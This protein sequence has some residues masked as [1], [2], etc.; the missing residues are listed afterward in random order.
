MM[1]QACAFCGRFVLD[2]D[3]WTQFLTVSRGL[4]LAAPDGSAGTRLS[5]HLH[6]SCLRASPQR[7][8]FREAFLQ[9]AT[10]SGHDPLT[11]RQGWQYEVPLHEGP[12]SSVYFAE[13]TGQFLVVEHAGPWYVMTRA[14]RDTLRDTGELLGRS[15]VWTGVLPQAVDNGP[16]PVQSRPL[17]ELLDGL[18]V[19]DLYEEALRPGALRYSP[20]EYFPDRRILNYSLSVPVPLP[21]DARAF[22]ADDRQDFPSVRYE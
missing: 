3:G 22:L 14:E 4:E 21:A 16:R 10:T 19:L 8:L 13:R 15:G 5:G 9:L 17:P 11:G 12:E 6:H 2:M 18:G 7:T 1:E 20:Y